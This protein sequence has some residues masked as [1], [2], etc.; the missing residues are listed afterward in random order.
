MSD[1]FELYGKNKSDYVKTKSDFVKAPAP[2][3]QKK[4]FQEQRE[5][6]FAS[7]LASL[8]RVPAVRCEAEPHRNYLKDY[9][10]KAK[11]LVKSTS[12]EMLRDG[13]VAFDTETTGIKAAE[14][15]IIQLAAIRFENFEPTEAFMTFVKPKKP[16]PPEATAVNGITDN[17]VAN[18]PQFCEILP[19]F[20]DFIGKSPL[21]AHNAE[22]DCKFLYVHGMDSI[23]KKKVFDTLDI[24]RKITRDYDGETLYN[25][26][27][28]TVCNHYKIY[29]SNA[30]TALA[31]SLAV[32][33]LFVELICERHEA[34]DKYSRNDLLFGTMK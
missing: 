14:N 24:S 28:S 10:F 20:E 12:I 11:P 16:I 13:F 22:F 19:S 7:M 30:H 1:Y 26:K 23:C 33:L 17:V 8:R 5:D 25:Y 27:L 6:E 2:Q 21:V 34:Y 15:S 3:P 18:A 9:E 4:S 31:D 29:F 32:G